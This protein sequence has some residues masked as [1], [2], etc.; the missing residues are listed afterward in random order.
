MGDY[1]PSLPD[2]DKLY[3]DLG[4]TSRKMGD[5]Q[6]ALLVCRVETWDTTA[7]T[8]SPPD[9]RITMRFGSM[10]KTTH[11]GPDDK[12]FIFFSRPLVN[13]KVGQSVDFDLWDRDV[14]SDDH[15]C[16]GKGT[17]AGQV[18]F[19]IKGSLAKVDCRAE[20]R[21]EVEK[22]LKDRLAAF[23]ISIARIRS[24]MDSAEM[25]DPHQLPDW[26]LHHIG[27]DAAE[28]DL[29]GLAALVGWDD[30]RVERRITHREE[31][32]HHW[33]ERLH[34]AIADLEAHAN[35]LD[36][37]VS[38]GEH[39]AMSAAELQCNNTS[40]NTA[41]SKK[42]PAGKKKKANVGPCQLEVTLSADVPWSLEA[43]AFGERVDEGPELPQI[44]LID[45]QGKVF[46]LEAAEV[47]GSDGNGKNA[48]GTKSK[49]DVVHLKENE[50]V[51]LAWRTRET[52]AAL[53]ASNLLRIVVVGSGANANFFRLGEHEEH[54][55]TSPNTQ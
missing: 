45:N 35:T 52:E 15:I 29:L 30:P 17:Y 42:T 10:P 36:K 5:L 20:T 51:R 43:G 3:E 22:D 47:L 46:P 25:P 33:T 40:S 18:P 54:E 55:E 32:Q 24:R 27:W 11:N 50:E 7:D 1:A 6:E 38:V 19:T 21:D 16:P 4:E 41:P 49:S 8:F 34:K 9:M 2:A 28:E 44:A 14:L 48:K 53:P 13:L 31:A 26:G 37:S 23:D 39:V 12:W